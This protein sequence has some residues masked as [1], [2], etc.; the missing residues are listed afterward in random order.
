MMRAFMAVA[1]WIAAVQ[2]TITMSLV[3][4]AFWEGGQVIPSLFHAVTLGGVWY[5]CG[6]ALVGLDK[7]AK[8][9]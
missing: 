5:C 1:I 7:P 3:A 2:S 6:V 4:Y 9:N 8:G